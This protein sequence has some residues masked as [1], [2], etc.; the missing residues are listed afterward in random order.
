[1]TWRPGD[2][3]NRSQDRFVDAS[4]CLS[5]GGTVDVSSGVSAG[6]MPT[7]TRSVFC[8]IVAGFGARGKVYSLPASRRDSGA[9]R[10]V[11]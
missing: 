10:P 5:E 11:D 3:Q 8:R 9:S 1:M 6:T 4:Q 2:P 7:S